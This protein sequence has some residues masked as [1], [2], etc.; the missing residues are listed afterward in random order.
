MPF[1]PRR[2]ADIFWIWDRLTWLYGAFVT[3]LRRTNGGLGYPWSQ[4]FVVLTLVG[5]FALWRAR[6]D[7][8]LVFLLP[9]VAA[10]LASVFHLTPS[11]AA[12]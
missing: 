7:V 4:L 3:G 5:Y 6:R 12:S 1:P 10:I 2:F 8:A 11:A 9:V